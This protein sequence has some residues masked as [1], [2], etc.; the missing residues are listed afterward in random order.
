MIPFGFAVGDFIAV[1]DLACKIYRTCKHSKTEFKTVA[2][3]ARTTKILARRFE[4][5]ARDQHS[6]LNRYGIIRQRELVCLVQ[7]LKQALQELD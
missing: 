4:D 1:G 6:I 5:E 2:S 7:G 3:E